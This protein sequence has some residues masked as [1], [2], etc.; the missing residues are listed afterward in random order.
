M[1]H[2]TILVQMILEVQ[3]RDSGDCVCS[4][5]A[6]EAS[7]FLLPLLLAEIVNFPVHPLSQT[8]ILAMSIF[9][10][11]LPFQVKYFQGGQVST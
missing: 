7:L 3:N 4:M 8:T 6:E 9:E 5:E 11:R 10:S 1:I 2:E